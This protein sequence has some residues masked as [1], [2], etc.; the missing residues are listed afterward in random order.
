M[1][2][3]DA[4]ETRYGIF[5]HRGASQTRPLAS[6]AFHDSE[7]CTE[8]SLLYDAFTE[9][10]RESYKDIWGLNLSD[11][12]TLPHYVTR[13]LREITP[14]ITKKRAKDAETVANDI[15]LGKL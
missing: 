6:V 14:E 1:V 12:L 5:D 11:F 10:A 13:M 3:Y 15:G 8:N 9:Y 2:L 4:Y 7:N